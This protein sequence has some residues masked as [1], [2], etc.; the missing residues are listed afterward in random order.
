VV[1]GPLLVRRP[2][3]SRTSSICSCSTAVSEPLRLASRVPVHNVSFNAL[4][5]HRSCAPEECSGTLTIS[6]QGPVPAS[7]VFPAGVALH[8]LETGVQAIQLSPYRADLPGTPPHTPGHGCRFPGM[9]FSPVTL[10]GPGQPSDPETSP[11]ISARYAGDTTVRLMAHEGPQALDQ[12]VEGRTQRLR[13][14]LRRPPDRRTQVN[15]QDQ[16]HRR[17]DRPAGSAF[18]G[19]ARVRSSR[20]ASRSPRAAGGCR[21]AARTR[22]TRV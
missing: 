1:W 11:L 19:V 22:R 16:L 5:G 13:H 20:G 12:P 15:L 3:R 9:L 6:P 21:R 7:G 10:S 17:L 4:T 2:R 18:T 8:L 14:H